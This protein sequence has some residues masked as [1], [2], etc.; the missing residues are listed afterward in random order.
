MS[1]PLQ[2]LNAVELSFHSSDHNSFH[3]ETLEVGIDEKDGKHNDHRYRCSD[4][5]R[6]LQ[7]GKVKPLPSRRIPHDGRKRRCFVHIFIEH[8]LQREQLL[9]RHQEQSVGK[10]VPLADCR[11]N[12]DCGY[13]R[14][15]QREHDTSEYNPIAS[16]VDLR[17]FLKRS[18]ERFNERFD[19]DDKKR[20]YDSWQNIREKVVRQMEIEHR[21]IPRDNAC[22]KIHRNDYESVPK[23]PRPHF[24]FS[25]QEAQEGGSAHSKRSADYRTAK[26]YETGLTKSGNMQHL[27]II[28]EMN[29]L[30]EEGDEP[31]T[32]QIVVAN[33]VDEQ[34][35]E[36]KNTEQRDDREYEIIDSVEHG[37]TRALFLAHTVLLLAV[38]LDDTFAANDF[39]EAVGE[40]QQCDADKR[41]QHADC[42]RERK[43]V[44]DQTNIINIQVKHLDVTFVDRVLENKVLFYTIINEV[45][46][47]QQQQHE[48]C[49]HNAW[50]GN[51]PDR[52]EPARAVHSRGFIQLLVDSRNGS[53]VQNGAPSKPL[54]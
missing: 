7:V 14:R 38:R 50:N 34:V 1:H 37:V 43:I 11:E 6:R 28:A 23:F 2:P 40:K 41:F 13:N 3:E 20:R 16:S 52:A 8:E 48:I 32:A 25:E 29:F 51:M 24:L 36:G 18:R 35:I 45:G 5:G 10:R 46:N 17:G 30:G 53:H 19:Q 44:A 26:R 15:N 42:R 54:P 49:R 21:N 33:R 9:I 22:V 39:G 12:G 4:R 47:R 31:S 27:G